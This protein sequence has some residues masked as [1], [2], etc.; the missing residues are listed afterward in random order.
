MLQSIAGHD[1]DDLISRPRLCRTRSKASIGAA[2]SGPVSTG[3]D[4][5]PPVWWPDP[6]AQMLSW[7]SKPSSR[8]GS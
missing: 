2:V 7:S 6:N 4:L 8:G 3:H 1:P 5:H